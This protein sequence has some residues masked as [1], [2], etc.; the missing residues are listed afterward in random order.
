MEI[1]EPRRLATQNY[2]RNKRL[3]KV[4]DLWDSE[5]RTSRV[6]SLSNLNKKYRCRL[7]FII[8]NNQKVV[9]ETG[10]KL[11]GI[12]TSWDCVRVTAQLEFRL[13]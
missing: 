10:Q 8:Y 7:N 13:S 12:L 1:T 9:M 5:L 2:G 6:L 3:R 11:S 4:A